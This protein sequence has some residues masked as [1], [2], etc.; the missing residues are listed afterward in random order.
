MT[1][2]SSGADGASEMQWPQ[3]CVG[4][5]KPQTSEQQQFC[6]LDAGAFSTCFKMQLMYLQTKLEVRL[7][8][9]DS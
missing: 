5:K 4:K 7:A 2:P 8:L 9:E 6:V 1:F 3:V